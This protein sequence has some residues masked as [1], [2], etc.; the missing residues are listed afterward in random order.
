M[1]LLQSALTSERDALLARIERH[2]A[3]LNTARPHLVPHLHR[4][5]EMR[6]EMVGVLEK[7]QTD[8]VSA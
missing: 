4:L 6:M 7:Y 2:R 3:A 8:V 5:I 1:N